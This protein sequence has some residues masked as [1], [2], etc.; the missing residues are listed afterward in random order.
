[1]EV[2][3]VP[4]TGGIPVRLTEGLGVDGVSRLFRPAASPDGKRVAIAAER[5]ATGEPSLDRHL[6]VMDI[7]GANAHHVARIQ[8][9]PGFFGMSWY[10][11]SQRMLFSDNESCSNNIVRV[12][13]DQPGSEVVVYDVDGI[14]AEPR[15][16]PVDQNQVLFNEQRCAEMGTLRSL[17]LD[18]GE[19][20]PV[21]NVP[22]KDAPYRHVQWSSDGTRFTFTVGE[23]IA[24]QEISG[25]I[26]QLPALEAGGTHG[27]PVFGDD[28]KRIFVKWCSSGGACDLVS[29][30]LESG[31][32]TLLGV[33]NI[34]EDARTAYTVGWARYTIDI[35]ADSD[36]LADGLSPL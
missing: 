18:S 14:A 26:T 16:N 30:D 19:V 36:G 34:F 1:M 20:T 10:Q 9:G 33:P 13:V 27:A 22:E 15:I 7:D 28:D 32:Q 2:W 11:D 3:A 8:I 35:D 23:A 5:T 25:A 17:A 31:L 24:I 29:I 4:D 12:N 6:W 21:P